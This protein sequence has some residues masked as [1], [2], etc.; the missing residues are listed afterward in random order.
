MVL[1]QGKTTAFVIHLCDGYA[2]IIVGIFGKFIKPGNEDILLDIIAFFSH[3]V[4][5]S[6]KTNTTCIQIPILNRDEYQQICQKVCDL[7][8]KSPSDVA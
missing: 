3:G 7:P 8:I 6:V 4:P 2:Q 5:L 1:G